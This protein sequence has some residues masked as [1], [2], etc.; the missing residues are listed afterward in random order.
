MLSHYVSHKSGALAPRSTLAWGCPG[1][2]PWR[3]P[4]AEFPGSTRSQREAL[5]VEQLI[6][7][8]KVAIGASMWVRTSMAATASTSI[9]GS[10]NR[11]PTLDEVADHY[12]RG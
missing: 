3:Q 11:T 4:G 7:Q 5:P 1:A 6:I 12:Q 8:G 9:L 10:Y 2:R